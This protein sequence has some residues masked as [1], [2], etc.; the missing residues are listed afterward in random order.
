MLYS[1]SE[2]DARDGSGHQSDRD[3]WR[4]VK[5]DQQTLAEA[6]DALEEVM[7]TMARPHFTQTGLSRVKVPR[8]GCHFHMSGG[9]DI[10]FAFPGVKL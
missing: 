7:D 3:S 4:N 1:D 2:G 9:D 8:I 10:S 6:R 5:P